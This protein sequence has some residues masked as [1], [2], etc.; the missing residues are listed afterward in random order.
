VRRQDGFESNIDWEG[1]VTTPVPFAPSNLLLV[2]DFFDAG[3][4]ARIIAEMRSAWGGPATIYQPDAAS[5]VDESL[6]K[7]TRL[8]LSEETVTFVRQRLLGHKAA[9]EEHFRVSLGGC[10]DPQFLRYEAGDFFVAH[11]DGNSLA[12]EF[13]HLRIRRVSVVIFLSSQADAPAP[14]A[15]CGGSLVFFDQGVDPGRRELGLSLRGEAGTLVAFRA[16]TTHEVTRVTHG[17]RHSVVCWY[18]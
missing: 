15:Y 5:P 7:T 8:M 2:R 4:C 14:G 16:E 18:R 10:E 13:D 17:E 3:T 11:Q 12:L 6:R 1:A 9:V